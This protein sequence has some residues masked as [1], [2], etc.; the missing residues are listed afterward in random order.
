[1]AHEKKEKWTVNEIDEKKYNT[2]ESNAEK[3]EGKV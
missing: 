1:M 3:K 2:K